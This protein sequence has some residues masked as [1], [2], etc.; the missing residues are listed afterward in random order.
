MT[1]LC[2]PNYQIK[3]NFNAIFQD[4]NACAHRAR[5]ITGYPEFGSG[6]YGM[7]YHAVRPN[8][9]PIE[10]LWNHLGCAVQYVLARVTNRT[11]LA[12][13][14]QIWLRTWDG[15]PQ[16]NVAGLVISMRRCQAVVAVYDSS[17]HS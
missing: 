10:H 11:T 6:E 5:I 8:L 17:T 9:N 15:I 3:S 13:L 1:Y 12:D 2:H 14:K 16:Q 4:D 7:A